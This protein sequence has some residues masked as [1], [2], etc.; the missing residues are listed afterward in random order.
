MGEARNTTLGTARSADQI[1]RHLRSQLPA[2]GQACPEPDE[3]A[4]GLVLPFCNTDTMNM[5]LAKIALHVAPGAHAVVLMDQ[6]DW[7]PTPKLGLPANI[8]V[9]AIP[10][11]SPEL[12]PQENIW[13]FTRDNGLANPVFGSDDEIV[14]HCCDPCNK[15]VE[16][17]WR[18]MSLGLRKWTQR[19]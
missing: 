12:N 7:H 18:I 4:A 3:G 2:G 1:G 11:K 9:I 13:Q 6:A 10:S 19:F 8:S 17:P 16:Q 14:D 5:H 15:L